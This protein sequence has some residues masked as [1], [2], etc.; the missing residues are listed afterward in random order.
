MGLTSDLM[1]TSLSLLWSGLLLTGAGGG[2]SISTL[3]GRN[4]VISR[5]SA[6]SFLF[7]FSESFLFLFPRPAEVSASLA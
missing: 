3:F 1:L 5:C 4:S 6:R 2:S 7:S